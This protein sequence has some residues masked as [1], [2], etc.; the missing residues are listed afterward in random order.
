MKL[1]TSAI[2]L[3]GGASSRMGRPKALLEYRGGTFL[4][5][6]ISLYES[7]GARVICV[8]GHD[9]ARIAASL[10]RAATAV[11]VL[12]PHPERGQL[13]SLQCGLRALCPDSEAFFFTPA[14]SPGVRPETLALLLQSFD[15]HSADFWQPSVHGVHGHPVLAPARMAAPLL[16]L[17]AEGSARDLIRRSR[18]CFVE[19]D[20]EG[21]VLD[22][23]TPEAYRRLLGEERP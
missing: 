18:R 5:R 2:L 19:T 4:D 21:A 11:L 7:I 15:G 10:R 6:Q 8:L 3:A 9:A 1:R 17:P 22:I 13:S 12:N 20:D 23:D 16:A 14:D